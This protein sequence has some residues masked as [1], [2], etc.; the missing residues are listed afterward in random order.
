MLRIITGL[1]IQ[2]VIKGFPEMVE[3]LCWLP[4][5]FGKAN[6]RER[7]YAKERI[8][9]GLTHNMADYIIRLP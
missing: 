1:E 9:R 5:Y 6:A 8:Q 4:E 3:K 7:A 2:F